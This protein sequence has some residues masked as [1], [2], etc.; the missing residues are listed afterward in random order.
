LPLHDLVAGVRVGLAGGFMSE[1]LGVSAGGGLVV[2]SNLSLGS[3]QHVVQGISLFAQ[4]PPT[5]LSGIKRYWET[6]SRAPT[7]WLILLTVGF[8]FGGVAGA[9]AAGDVSGAFLRWAYV[10]YLIA[11]GVLMIFRP[12]CVQS[13]GQSGIS[14]EEFIGRRCSAG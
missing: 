8:L 1:L 3:E 6:G 2:A 10:L 13:D 4:I 11:L 14:S 5:C 12:P 9:L 7:S